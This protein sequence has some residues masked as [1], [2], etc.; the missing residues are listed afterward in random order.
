MNKRPYTD[1]SSPLSPICKE[2]VIL[3]SLVI[4]ICLWIPDIIL[5]FLSGSVTL[6]ADAIKSGN[7][8]IST[9]FTWIALRKIAKGESQIYDYGMGKFESLT[10]MITGIIMFLSLVL[11]FSITMYKLLNPS[12]LHKEATLAALIMMGIGAIVNL[13]LYREKKH[14]AEKE[15][16]PAIEAQMRLFKTKAITDTTVLAA[17]VPAVLLHEYSWSVYI[18]PL[19]SLVVIGIFLHSGYRIISSLLPDLL[20]KTIDEELQLVIVRTLSEFFEDYEAFHGVRSRR[21]GKHI[22]IEI[23]LEFPGERRM[24]EVQAIINRMKQSLEN[25]IPNSSVIIVPSS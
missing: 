16:S 22:Y 15:Y 18:D 21:G 2:H 24:A 6:Y 9:F 20:D 19:A 7:E 25:E 17:L 23:F 13:W 1:S 10:G 14:L 11:I 5:A 3:K 8:I 12:L 4:D